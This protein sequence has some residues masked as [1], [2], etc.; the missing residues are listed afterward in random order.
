MRDLQRCMCSMHGCSATTAGR[1]SQ[2]DIAHGPGYLVDVMCHVAM[3]VVD[4]PNILATSKSS[5]LGSASSH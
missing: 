5:G 1:R 4:C 2:L 3:S